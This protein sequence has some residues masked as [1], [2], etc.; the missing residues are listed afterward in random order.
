MPSTPAPWPSSTAT[1][2]T[3]LTWMWPM[4]TMWS[5]LTTGRTPSTPCFWICSST[6]STYTMRSCTWWSLSRCGTGRTL[7]ATWRKLLLISFWRTPSQTPG[8]SRIPWWW[9]GLNSS[10]SLPPTSTQ[11]PSTLLKRSGLISTSSESSTLESLMS[12]LKGMK[13]CLRAVVGSGRKMSWK[14]CSHLFS[15]ST[16]RSPPKML[17]KRQPSTLKFRPFWLHSADLFSLILKYIFQG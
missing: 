3:T 4:L 1:I 14:G 16:S 11:K 13:P 8:S 15:E 2:C 17:R 6:P 9:L 5:S 10:T 7:E 12:A